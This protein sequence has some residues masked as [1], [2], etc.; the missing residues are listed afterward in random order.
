MNLALLTFELRRAVRNR[1]TLMFS[2]VLP[3]FFFL[4]FAAGGDTEKLGGLSSRPYIMISMAT[5]GAMNA[6]FTGG[7]I[8]AGERAAGWPRQL[9]IAGLRSRDYLVAKTAIAY[10]AAV[11]GLLAVFALGA[12]TDV[13]MPPL[14][15][16]EAGASVLVGLLPIAALGIAIGYAARPQSLA[17]IFG[18]GSAMLSLLGGLWAP[19]ETLPSGLQHVVRALPSYWS[20]RAGR[21]VVLGSWV[22]W[23]GLFVIAGWTL[24]LGALA[25]YAYRR[26]GLRPSAA[27]TT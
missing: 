27:G 18:I 12:M 17:P 3:V 20:A 11:P 8:I 15:W 16:L 6:L 24:A 14:Q 13:H 2:A 4:T 19:T 1:R 25:A 10:V 7:G 9:R 23:H 5:Y 21:S 26:D 22:G